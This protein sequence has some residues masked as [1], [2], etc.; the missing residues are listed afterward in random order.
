MKQ[1]G[2]TAL[3]VVGTGSWGMVLAVHVARK[4]LSVTLLARTEGE[5]RTL[6]EA[7][8][9]P[10]MPGL[11][12]PPVL[13]VTHEAQALRAASVVLFVVPT[14]SMR[15][16]ARAVTPYLA[17]NAILVSASKGLEIES[18]RSMSQVIHEETAVPLERICA[19]S[20]PNLAKEIAAG[21]PSST[22]VACPDLAAAG[23]VQELV[24]S[25]AFRVY[26]HDDLTGVELA[27]ALKNVVALGAGMCDGLEAGDNGKAALMTRGLAEMARLGKAVGAQP[28]TFSGLAGLGDLIATC[29]S[30]LS[31]NRTT[32]ERLA[33]GERLA[34]IQQDMRQVAEGVPTTRA[35]REL[36]R[37]HGVEMPIVELMNEVLFNDMPVPEAGRALMQRDPKHE[38]EGIL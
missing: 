14:Q 2:Y 26:T 1:S 8:E 17:E 13:T 36:A 4:G 30:P 11:R 28:L 10:R 5:A 22:V 7:G 19:L 3:A 24:G 21:K 32:G 27:G 6:T 12:F 9:S 37:R 29:M 25:P 35:A 18:T 16:N 34:A 15:D 33:R 31:R 38:L 23:V 20:G